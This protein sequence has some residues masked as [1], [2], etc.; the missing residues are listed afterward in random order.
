MSPNFGVNIWSGSLGVTSVPILGSRNYLFRC[1]TIK[2]VLYI[3]TK[4]STPDSFRV[5]RE[6]APR[7]EIV[8]PKGMCF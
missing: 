6:P 5:L 4:S 1:Y 8:N 3:G 2:L 7:Q